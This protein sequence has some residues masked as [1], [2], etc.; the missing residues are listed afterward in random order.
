LIRLLYALLAVVAAVELSTFATSIY[1]HRC[2][3]HRGVQLNR[4]VAF[5]MR[6]ELW[7]GTG[8]ESK[9]W[10]AVH[11]KHHR[12]TDVLGDP[13]SPVLE[14]LWHILLGNAFYYEREAHNPETLVKFAPDV[15]N[16]WFDRHVFRYGLL[17]I[18]LGIGIFIWLLGPLW[19][20]GAYIAQAGIYVFLNAVINGA[21]HA[22]GYQ[23][24]DNTATN[25]RFVA[26]LTAGEGLH[27]NH[28]AYPTSARF[29]IRRN[30]FDPSWLV[31]RLLA[32]MRLARP[33]HVAAPSD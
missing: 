14:G 12:H 23:N 25:L 30:E 31:L 11:R 16:D 9:E 32:W 3:A 27:N 20:V 10:V 17:G 7:L 28:H 29:S 6:L 5:L 21:N 26:L 33:L 18:A 13:H 24:F 1:L 22:V 19:G 8:I 15:G 2:L 4:F